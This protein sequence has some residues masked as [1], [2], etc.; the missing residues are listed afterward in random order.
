[1]CKTTAP[2]PVDIIWSS[3][4]LVIVSSQSPRLAQV[5]I[6]RIEFLT[7]DKDLITFVCVAQLLIRG[8]VKR[9]RKIFK[10][11]IIL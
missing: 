5:S 7:F 9:K 6:F 10:D 4:Q 2:V 1:L 8:S 11:F 3:A